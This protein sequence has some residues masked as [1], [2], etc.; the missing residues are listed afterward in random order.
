MVEETTAASHGLKSDIERLSISVDAFDLGE[1]PEVGASA[2]K[3]QKP[4]SMTK[5]SPQPRRVTTRGGALPKEQVAQIE[6]GWEEF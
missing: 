2:A 3:R 5:A 4:L 6:E 1:R